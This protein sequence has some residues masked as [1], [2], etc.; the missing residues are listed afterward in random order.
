MG[1]ASPPDTVVPNMSVG[2]LKML[3]TTSL[4]P[5]AASSLLT[6]VLAAPPF[7]LLSGCSPSMPKFPQ[8]GEEGRL[9]CLCESWQVLLHP[10]A[11]LWGQP[12]WWQFFSTWL[13][14]THLNRVSRLQK[15]ESKRF[16]FVLQHISAH[17]WLIVNLSSS[18][19]TFEIRIE[20]KVPGPWKEM[21]GSQNEQHHDLAVPDWND[22]SIINKL[23][24]FS[25]RYCK[26]RMAF[27]LEIYIL[28]CGMYQSLLGWSLQ[29]PCRQIP[30]WDVCRYASWCSPVVV[31]KLISVSS[32]P[33]KEHRCER[34]N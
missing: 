11:T 22:Q 7:V 13:N 27:G 3:I 5:L 6:S 1:S 32:I 14:S 23:F 21:E 34:Q 17:D 28:T 15:T 33:S 9:I 12:A 8:M 4:S 16:C 18:Q 29:L 20:S 24:R 25:H 26:F 31:L 2:H 10:V 19:D 30:P